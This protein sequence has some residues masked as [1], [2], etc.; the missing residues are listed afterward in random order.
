MTVTDQLDRLTAAP[1]RMLYASLMRNERVV[2]EANQQAK[3][4]REALARKTGH[5]PSPATTNPP[6]AVGITC[7]CGWKQQ[8]GYVGDKQ[9]AVG[10][11][12]LTEWE[13]A[14]W[15]GWEGVL[16]RIENRFYEE[17]VAIG[18]ASEWTI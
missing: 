12:I 11:H 16:Y 6:L 13:K 2:R 17:L 15:E 4:A 10:Q 8:G 5:G 14:E 3:S 18:E 7:T 1:A 9:R